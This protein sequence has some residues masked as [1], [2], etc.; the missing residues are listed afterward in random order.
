MKKSRAEVLALL[1]A[2]DEIHGADSREIWGDPFFNLTFLKS[3]EDPMIPTFQQKQNP[4]AY[5][6]GCPS[7]RSR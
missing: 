1:Y 6:Q 4:R 5:T 2:L 7:Q 3:Y